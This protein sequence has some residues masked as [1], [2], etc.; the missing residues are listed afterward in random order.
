VHQGSSSQRRRKGNYYPSNW[1][2]GHLAVASF[3]ASVTDIILEQNKP[4]SFE[5]APFQYPNCPPPSTFLDSEAYSA[6]LT[7]T[8]NRELPNGNRTPQRISVFSIRW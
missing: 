5:A 3:P 4:V 1:V 8:T 7:A 6:F 2:V